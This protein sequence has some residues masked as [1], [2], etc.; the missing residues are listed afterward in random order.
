MYIANSS[1]TPKIIFESITDI[2]REEGNK[3]M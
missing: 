2:S 3:T 1:T